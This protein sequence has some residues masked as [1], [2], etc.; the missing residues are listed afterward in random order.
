MLVLMKQRLFGGYR[1]RKWKPAFSQEKTVAME[2]K[3]N[4]EGAIRLGDK[5]S[6]AMRRSSESPELSG[7]AVEDFGPKQRCWAGER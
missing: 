4:P 2:E 3:D 7:N 1:V 6:L 5:T